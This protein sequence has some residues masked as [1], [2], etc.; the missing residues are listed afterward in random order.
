MLRNMAEA[1]GV[2]NIVT[3]GETE[4]ADSHVEKLVPH[5]S[6]TCLTADVLGHTMVV[7]VGAPGRHIAQNV[8]AVLVTVQLVGAD[9]AKAGLAMADLA[10]VK[11]RG[12]SLIHI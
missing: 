8:M 4:G 2:S 5:G 1:K 11:G 12:L 6:C 3:F 10:A 9:L 7:K